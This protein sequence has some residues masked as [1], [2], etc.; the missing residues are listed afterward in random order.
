MKKTLLL[1]DI[2]YINYNNNILDLNNYKL[3]DIKKACKLYK[4][5]V[6]A[7]KAILVNRLHNYFIRF[8]KTIIIQKYFRRYI[9]KLFI[10]LKGPAFYNRKLSV[11]DTDCVT[12]ENIQDIPIENFISFTLENNT[13]Y[14]FDINSLL[15]SF[16]YNIKKIN[17][18]TRS[19]IPTYV[20]FNIYKSYT[21]RC[22]I[23]NHNEV[24]NVKFHVPKLNRCFN[25][26]TNNSL[27]NYNPTIRNINFDNNS[28][29]IYN[30]IITLRNNTFIRRVHNIFIEIDSLGNY[31]NHYWFYNLSYIKF[32]RLYR[33]IYDL[34]LF[35]LNL[36][37]SVK[38][39]ICPFHSPF[40]NVFN[41]TLYPYDVSEQE[42]RYGCLIVFENLLYSGINNEY[43]KLGALYILT[44]LTTVSESARNSY[45][46]LFESLGIY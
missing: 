44:A 7:K 35:R 8:Q 20:V 41:N 29:N 12:L 33:T 36:T 18:Y 27:L 40:Q 15:N 42:L 13:I 24:E 43:K 22:I 32:K 6:T 30:E 45:P 10:N 5:R 26:S 31:S 23:F 38:N 34:W 39:R 28:I 25:N 1:P 21:L 19:I 14:S 3:P 9:V 16:K 2:N 4:L 46:Y 37:T 17:P 11:N